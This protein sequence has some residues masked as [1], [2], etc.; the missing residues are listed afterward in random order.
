MS[1]RG[2]LSIGL[3]SAALAV[4]AVA[5][6]EDPPKA[7]TEP[8]GSPQ[9]CAHHVN[10]MHAMSNDME[11]EAYCHAHKDCM[12]HNCGGMGAKGHGQGP[13]DPPGPQAQPKPP[14]N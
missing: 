9:S 11:R 13:V 5:R 12:S 1:L 8:G 14:K 2:V 6:A 4:G 10:A 3:I 7:P